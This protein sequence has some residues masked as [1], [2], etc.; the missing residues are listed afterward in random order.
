MYEK[1]IKTGGKLLL[2][3]VLTTIVRI[4]G[5]LLI[6]AGT[7]DVLKPSVFVNNGTMPI[8]FTI[9]GILAYTIIAFM[10]LLVKD[11]ISGNRAIRGLKYSIS[12]CLVWVVYLLEPLPHVAFMVVSRVMRKFNFG[13][14]QK[15][16]TGGASAPLDYISA[17]R[18]QRVKGGVSRS[19]C[20]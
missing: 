20:P 8:A 15:S 14:W 16:I 13:I 6:P 7:Q 10:F 12:C 11:K 1:R 5:Q 3:G 9:Y 18:A 4:I 2:I 19:S 17:V